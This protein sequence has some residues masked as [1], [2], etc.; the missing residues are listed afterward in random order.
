MME[1]ARLIIGEERER[2]KRSVDRLIKNNLGGREGT[3]MLGTK[4][5]R[6]RRL[7]T[8][9]LIYLLAEKV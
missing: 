2:G 7:P 6:S 9:L 1:C 4:R 3:E 5:G 8:P